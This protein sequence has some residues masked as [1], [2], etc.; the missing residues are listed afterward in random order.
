[1]NIDMADIGNL[2]LGVT[3]SIAIYLGAT[4][5]IAEAAMVGSIGITI[6][7]FCSALDNYKFKKSQAVVSLS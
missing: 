3:G 4:G 1:M 7:A 6:K 2:V 5:H